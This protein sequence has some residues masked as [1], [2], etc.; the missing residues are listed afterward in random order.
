MRLPE[1]EYASVQ[2]SSASFA[3][4]DQAQRQA[5]QTIETG[6]AEFGR[7]LVRTQL[8]A[9]HAKV[10]A[11]L[12]DVETKIGASPYL[13][14]AFV[15][16]R[17][18]DDI[19]SL[20]SEVQRR[21][22]GEGSI[23]TWEVAGALH[24]KAAKDLV[25]QAGGEMTVGSGW[26]SEFESG[27][28]EEIR[29]RRARLE[30]AQ[31]RGMLADQRKTLDEAVANSIRAGNFLK[32]HNLVVQTTAF[33][34]AEK[35]QRLGI[36]EFAQQVRPLEARRLAGIRSTADVLEAGRLIGQLE[37]GQGLDR[38]SPDQRADWKR[39]LEGQVREFEH[40]EKSAAANQFREADEAARNTLL[41]AYIQAGGRQL[42]TKL[43]PAP[44]TVSSETL[45]WSIRLVESTR[46]DK[47]PVE[48]D[49]KAYAELTNLATTN[50]EAF[51]NA[52]LA[53]YFS[54]L[55]VPDAKHFLDLQRTLKLEGPSSVKYT[56]FFGPQ[57]E[58]NTRLVF[59]GLHVAGK[60]A[61]DDAFAVGYVQREVNRALYNAARAKAGKGSAAP[62]TPAEQTAIV[63]PLVDKL[64]NAKAWKAEAKDSGIPSDYSTAVRDSTLRRG[65]GLTPEAQKTTM[66]EFSAWEGD[67]TTGWKRSAGDRVL[68]KPE[69]FQVF[70]LIQ[71]QGP[72]I[73]AALQKAGKDSSST[74]IADMAVRAYLRGGR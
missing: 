38:L 71:T 36:I 74:A 47:K 5:A 30:Q 56:S 51:K 16:E 63:N 4:V 12:A 61:E 25:A 50:P 34:P 73:K 10:A 72:R 1:I 55:A 3:R 27:V 54:R 57:E 11:G 22:N 70:D 65:K 21:L 20:D 45:Q 9:A 59:H 8:E 33:E 66:T 13:D 35:E 43:I 44:G 68:T 32:A 40:G 15:R 23:P 18:G 58:T 62:L 31:L 39:V 69:A 37:S 53:S 42:S 26:K 6:L 67:I 14:K 41:G 64:V 48:T 2:D 7:S 29:G 60:D 52:D 19:G 46:P 28:A 17:L 49:L 24:A